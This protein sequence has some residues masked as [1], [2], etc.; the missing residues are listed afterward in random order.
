MMR[1]LNVSPRLDVAFRPH[2]RLLDR[3][4]SDWRIPTAYMDECDWLPASDIAET[5]TVYYV[6]MEL[7]GIDMEKLDISFSGGMLTVKGEKTKEVSIGECCHCAERYS[8]SFQRSFR[9]PG[10]VDKD[11]I[12][13][14]YKD[15]ILKV[16]L[17]KS[18]ESAVRKIEVH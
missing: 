11:K 5:D 3:F 12:E 17:E 7:P 16:N 18:E 4:F 2:D 15:G 9:I 10:N 1:M 6:T 8:G 14:T 13:A